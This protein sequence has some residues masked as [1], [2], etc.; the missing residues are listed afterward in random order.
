MGFIIHYL[1]QG[2]IKKIYI[3]IVSDHL[4]QNTSS[5]IRSLDFLQKQEFFKKIDKP[6]YIIW[7]DCGP[8]FRSYQLLHYF[9]VEMVIFDFLIFLINILKFLN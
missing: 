1:D 4:D 6:N 3:D 2:E 8:H 7:A 9:F 5:V